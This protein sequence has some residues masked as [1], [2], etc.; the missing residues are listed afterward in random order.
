MTTGGYGRCIR[1]EGVLAGE[2]LVKH[3]FES[4]F[5]FIPVIIAIEIIPAHLIYNDAHNQL[6]PLNC[7]PT[8]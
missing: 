7:L 4:P 1:N 3:S 5:Y 2:S 6:R 8:Y